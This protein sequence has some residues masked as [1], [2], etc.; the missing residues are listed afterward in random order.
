MRRC[1]VIST[2]GYGAECAGG[3]RRSRSGGGWLLAL[4]DPFSFVDGWG[5]RGGGGRRGTLL[6]TLFVLL[7]FW[8]GDAHVELGVR[9]AEG[10]HVVPLLC[11]LGLLH[12]LLA[13]LC[14]LHGL[15][16]NR[17][18]FLVLEGDEADSFFGKDLALV[19]YK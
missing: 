15:H 7:V 17:H 19:H 9:D 11:L 18:G 2:G 4:G 10:V 3:W 13:R 16:G 5:R 12:Q 14:I 1:H 6:Y 8:L